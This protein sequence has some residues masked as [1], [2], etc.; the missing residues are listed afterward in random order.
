MTC[1]FAATAVAG[2]ATP[3]AAVAAA[4]AGVW[5]TASLTD[6]EPAD[7]VAGAEAAEAPARAGFMPSCGMLARGFV[8]RVCAFAPCAFPLPN[9]GFRC[10]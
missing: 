7:A 5:P 2:D 4:V 8:L 3:A 6:A 1:G 9:R 10:C